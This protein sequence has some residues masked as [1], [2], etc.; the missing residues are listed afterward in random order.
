MFIVYLRALCLIA[1]I[2]VVWY[3]N[4]VGSLETPKDDKYALGDK[5]GCTGDPVAR[6]V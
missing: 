4:C 3:I 5:F 1:K 2:N 6:H